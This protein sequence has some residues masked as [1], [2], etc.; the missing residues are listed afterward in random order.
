MT[1]SV[2]EARENAG[3]LEWIESVY[4]D[5][6]DDL[7]LLNTGIF[8]SLGDIGQREPDPL[9]R[10]L[11][12]RTALLVT[13]L[14]D[15]QPAGFAMV[16]RDA[17]A[18]RQ[19]DYRMA[20]FFIDRS[21]RRRGLGRSAVRLI[22]DRFAGRWEITEY[23]RNPAAVQFWRKVVTGYT[24]GDYVERTANGEVRQYFTSLRSRAPS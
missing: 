8:H 4:R 11:M 17:H 12:D 15:R 2:R 20:E 21:R 23:T 6:L 9:Q 19:A 14:D 10:W 7:G 24:R 18:A 16:A 13:I 22:F 1:V 3:D 5:Y